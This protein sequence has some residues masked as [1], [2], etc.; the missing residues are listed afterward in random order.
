MYKWLVSVLR[1]TIELII[2]FIVGQ[3]GEL[4]VADASICVACISLAMITVA[5]Q[6]HR[7]NNVDN[8]IA[9]YENVSFGIIVGIVDR[10]LGLDHNKRLKERYTRA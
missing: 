2:E 3:P 9:F 1:Q 4:G 7:Y 10:Y 5:A 6:S 8:N